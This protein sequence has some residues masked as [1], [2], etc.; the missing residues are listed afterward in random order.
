MTLNL[1]TK[2]MEE[3]KKQPN[4]EDNKKPLD[5]LAKALEDVPSDL[6]ELNKIAKEVSPLESALDSPKAPESESAKPVVN[7]PVETPIPKP[8]PTPVPTPTPTPKTVIAPAT[9]TPAPEPVVKPSEKAEE[10][11]PVKK[12]SSIRTYANDIASLIK[13]GVSMTDIVLSEQQKKF[14]NTPQGKIDNKKDER[15]RKNKLLIISAVIF[16]IL[17]I[18]IIIG[19]FF[20]PKNGDELSVEIEIPSIILSNSTEEIH[21]KDLDRIGFIKTINR[22]IESAESTLGSIINF[23]ITIPDEDSNRIIGTQEFFN[24]IDA[25]IRPSFSR[26]LE[27]EFMLGAHSFDG[28]QGFLIFKVSSFDNAFSGILDWEK[29]MLEDLWPMFYEQKPNTF[30]TIENTENEAERFEKG[31]Q[32][33]I[34]KNRDAR[35]LETES[36]GTAIIYSFPDRN[37]LIITTEKSTLVEIF[38][39]LTTGRFRN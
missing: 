32:D 18:V 13:D 1:K 9:P 37:H 14:S 24:I 27:S 3:E 38:D 31:F 36:G 35:V 26:S 34:I 21:L 33:I 8:A 7:K 39:R 19:V 22:K 12:M 10:P 2:I 25:D 28:N 11:K 16:I 15:K 23:Y 17:S 6:S 5:N 4:K 29:R 20:I 30:T